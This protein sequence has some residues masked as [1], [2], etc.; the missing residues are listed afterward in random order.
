MPTPSFDD[1]LALVRRH[2]TTDG[3]TY[4]ALGS[5]LNAALVGRVM[6]PNLNDADAVNIPRPCVILDPAGGATEY[7][8]GRASF[9]LYLYAYSDESLGAAI[10]LYD[11]VFTSLHGSRLYD[12]DGAIPTAGTAR[13]LVRPFSGY[14]DKAKA[15]FA[16][17]NWTITLAG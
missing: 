4:A 12:P 10:R 7:G 1:A 3:T 13:E 2:L 9:L 8:R 11:A 15:H 6:G 14:N 17:G 16:R 5:T